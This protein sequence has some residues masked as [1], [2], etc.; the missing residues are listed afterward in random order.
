MGGESHHL[1]LETLVNDALMAIF[2]IVVGLEKKAISDDA[3]KL[4]CKCSEGSVRD[5][6]S[7]LDRALLSAKDNEDI[8]LETV[9]NIF[10]HFDKT[11][12]INLLQY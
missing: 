7:L 8:S 12:I 11:S 3:I 6:L 5:S 4:I 10:G 1:T 9:Q 2:F